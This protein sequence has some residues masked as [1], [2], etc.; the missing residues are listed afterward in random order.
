MGTWPVL[1]VFSHMQKIGNVPQDDM[2]R[3]FNMG[4]GMVLVVPAT[5]YKRV[6]TIIEK[7]G[8]KAFLIGRIVKG[9]RKVLYA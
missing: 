1:P 4:I 3:T 6:Q 2:M 9:E 7:A 8:E 5:K